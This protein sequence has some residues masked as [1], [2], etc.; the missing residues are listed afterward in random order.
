VIG[1]RAMRRVYLLPA[2]L[3]FAGPALLIVLTQG[4]FW[5]L[6][7]LWWLCAAVIGVISNRR[8]RVIVTIVLIPVCVLTL[9]EGG[10]V[11]LPAALTLLAIDA[12][13]SATQA[14]GH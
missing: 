1:V 5:P 4:A 10:P 11:M 14:L 6:A 12:T 13:F 9:F 3:A 7:I 8:R 2:L